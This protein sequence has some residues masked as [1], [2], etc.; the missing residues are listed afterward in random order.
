M[1]HRLAGVC[2]A[3]LLLAGSPVW[4]QDRDPVEVEAGAVMGIFALPYASLGIVRDPWVVRMSGGVMPQLEDCYGWQVNAGR[5]VRD[6]G[7]AKHSVGVM[8]A[9]FDRHCESAQTIR[10]RAQSAA[11]G[12][13]Y[14]YRWPTR[15]QY[16]GVTYTFQVFGFFIEAGP[17][18]GVPNPVLPD[19]GLLSH[20]YGQ[21]G[22]V[23]RFGKKYD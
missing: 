17:G 16:G 5:V 23:A 12:L 21:V 7:N 3:G 4:A 11:R 13:P 9:G 6:S 10:S 14:E 1:K 19:W 18:V 15:G 20:V 2:A 22:Y 8:W